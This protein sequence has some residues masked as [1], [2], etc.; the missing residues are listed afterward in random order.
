MVFEDI[1][2]KVICF[3]GG[4]RDWKNFMEKEMN[5]E[6]FRRSMNRRWEGGFF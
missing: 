3:F 1:K 6:M 4:W 2:E 5:R